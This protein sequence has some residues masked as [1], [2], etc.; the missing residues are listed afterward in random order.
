MNLPVKCHFVTWRE[1]PMW[2]TSKESACQ[3]RKCSFNPWAGKI[4]EVETA[5]HSSIPAWGTS[6]QRS[7]ASLSRIRLGNW[8]TISPRTQACKTLSFLIIFFF[9]LPRYLPPSIKVIFILLNQ[10]T[11]LMRSYCGIHCRFITGAWHTYRDTRNQDVNRGQQSK[12]VLAFFPGASAHL[13]SL[14]NWTPCSLLRH[15]FRDLIIRLFFWPCG[16]WNLWSKMKDPTHTPCSGN[17]ESHPLDH[18][19]VLRPD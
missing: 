18:Q 13:N 19:E 3:C 9:D 14:Q 1:L 11:T 8:T 2:L 15:C 7:L 6:W 10:R 12:S 4:P 17:A 5:T 16:I